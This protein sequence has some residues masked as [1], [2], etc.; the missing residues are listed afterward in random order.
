VSW[1]DDFLDNITPDDTGGLFRAAPGAAVETVAPVAGWVM[2]HSP[3]LQQAADTYQSV[4]D[5]QMGGASWGISALPGGP[6]TATWDEARQISPGQMA[7]TGAVLKGMGVGALLNND[8]IAEKASWLLPSLDPEFD[9]Y[10]PEDRKAAFQ[11]STYGMYA[12]GFTDAYIAWYSDPLVVA[13]KGV[14]TAITKGL[15]RPVTPFNRETLAFEIS[16]AQKTNLTVAAGG[17]AKK[18]SAYVLLNDLTEGDAARN[19]NHPFIKSSNNP[20]LL[21]H[22]TGE[23]TDFDQTAL[24]VRAAIGDQAALRGLQ[25]SHASIHDTL[26]TV[27]KLDEAD[28]A[29]LDAALGTL[30]PGAWT[31]NVLDRH[32]D[33]KAVLDDLRVKDKY[34]DRALDLDWQGQAAGKVTWS[35]SKTVEKARTRKAARRDKGTFASKGQWVEETYQR[36]PWVRPVRVM[37]WTGKERPAHYVAFSGANVMDSHREILATLDDIPIYRAAIKDPEM[38]PKFAARKRDIYNEWASLGTDTERAAFIETLE[39]TVIDDMVE[40]Y[41]AKYKHQLSRT[42]VRG[43]VDDYQAARKNVTTQMQ[44]SP[45]GFFLD[46]DGSLGAVPAWSSQLAESMPIMDFGLMDTLIRRHHSTLARNAG[47]ASDGAKALIEGF[48]GVWRPLTLLRGGYPIRNNAE[49]NMRAAAAYGFLPALASPGKSMA[50]WTRNRYVDMKYGTDVAFSARTRQSAGREA[51]RIRGV[52]GDLTDELTVARGTVDDYLKAHPPGTLGAPAVRPAEVADAEA[53]IAELEAAIAARNADLAVAVGGTL[54]PIKGTKTRTGQGEGEVFDGSQGKAAMA[55]SSAANTT[56]NTVFDMLD[57]QQQRARLQRVDGA[58]TRHNPGDDM[59]WDE[60]EW[61]VNRIIKN[62]PIGKRI[63]EGADDRTL[64]RWLADTPAGREYRRQTHMPAREMEAWVARQ[65]GIVERTLPDREMW[66]DV[67]ARDINKTEFQARMGARDDLAPIHGRAYKETDP[68]RGG[69]KQAWRQKVVTPGFKWLGQLPEDITVRH[70]FYKHVW[71]DEYARRLKIALDGGMVPSAENL[72]KIRRSAH[73]QALKETKETLYTIDRYSNSAAKLR[74]I[75][76]FFA[77]W[78]NTIKTW[79]KIGVRDPSVVARGYALW[80][81]PNYA[82]LVTDENGEQV[83]PGLGLSDTQNVQI[84]VPEWM[85]EKWFAGKNP[86]FSKGAVNV[87]LQGENPFLPGMGPQVTIAANMYA[88]EHPDV[89]AN[90][91]ALPGGETL[92]KSLLPFGEVS[93]DSWKQALTPW[94]RRLVTRW[95]GESS[96]EYANAYQS[97]Y[98]AMLVDIKL[99][100]RDNPGE[101]ALMEEAKQATDTWYLVRAAAGAT[102]PMALQFDSPYQFYIDAYRKH[103]RDNP[104]ESTRQAQEWFLTNYPEY[105]P[106]I[107]S[108]S[109]NPTGVASTL[110]AFEATRKYRGLVN[111]I[112]VG[113]GELGQYESN[114]IQMVTNPVMSEADFDQ[115]VYVWQYGRQVAA[116]SSLEFRTQGDVADAAEYAQAQEAWVKYGA[117]RA[118]LDRTLD[119][120]GWESIYD[121]PD[122]LREQWKSFKD[123]LEAEYPAWKADR[124]QIDQ[125]LA[126]KAVRSAQLIVDNEQFWN[127]HKDDQMWILVKDYVES[128]KRAVELMGQEGVNKTDLREQWARYGKTL[129]DRDTRFAEFYYRWFDNDKL[130]PL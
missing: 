102:L 98:A 127:D 33:Y 121:A 31:K 60:M 119:Q 101:Q 55:N 113:S 18:N 12:T 103:M 92:I 16:E 46:T 58:G 21:A 65:R 115:G 57:R 116:G 94:Q 109:K 93:E 124:Q 81:V 87:I 70:P 13:G 11:D 88:Q 130:E 129:S 37:Q 50:R 35:R 49:G 27:Q 17:K 53:R 97:T 62:D 42:I 1:F 99:G 59:Y 89:V 63:L 78:E 9:I 5:V 24:I 111:D 40:F 72:E 20:D 4:V 90:I 44:K 79:V 68:T 10:N 14:K 120:Y 71:D 128:R 45:E 2:D 126:S 3:G 38:G 118:E 26:K 76:P 74:W 15:E 22:L 114:M 96:K 122:N 25:A 82:G 41:S 56:E 28:A 51:A 73:R 32:G 29:A 69:I 64:V 84:P 95:Q 8:T 6:R 61:E 52:I 75:M 19:I 23:A 110:D 91:K 106:V 67:V 104:D 77:A 34:L 30:E 54:K 43:W 107:S 47:R 86:E 100:K 83:G 48:Y 123:G 39:R 105:F 7:G 66:P 112:A 80:N 125:G 85:R 108:L 36:N 117:G